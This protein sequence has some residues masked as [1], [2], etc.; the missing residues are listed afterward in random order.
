MPSYSPR[1]SKSSKMATN[2]YQKVYRNIGPNSPAEP[3]E[4]RGIDV[5]TKKLRLEKPGRSSAGASRTSSDYVMWDS[6]DSMLSDAL[7]DVNEL[8]PIASEVPAPLPND[9]LIEL[10]SPKRSKNQPTSEFTMLTRRHDKNKARSPS[11]PPEQV[12]VDGQPALETV[13][14]TPSAGD[15]PQS[16]RPK[17]KRAMEAVD[18]I[19]EVAEIVQRDEPRK[20]KQ[21]K[22]KLILSK[23]P[24]ED[25]PP[26]AHRPAL[27][28]GAR[29]TRLENFIIRQ[30]QYVDCDSLEKSHREDAMLRCKR[31]LM[32]LQLH[33]YAAKFNHCTPVIDLL[34][35]DDES[36][37]DS[38]SILSSDDIPKQTLDLA[39]IVSMME[40]DGLTSMDEFESLVRMV[41]STA[42]QEHAPETDMYR[43][44]DVLQRVFEY[45][46]AE[47][48]G[49]LIPY[50]EPLEPQS[51]PAMDCYLY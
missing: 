45:R 32:T 22:K 36:L 21:Q 9:A 35:L 33:P 26:P 34:P 20:E 41:F 44:A 15:S 40:S 43:M 2:P 7:D 11:S 25:E 3:E 23:K 12:P 51:L 31:M 39:S 27:V 10:P 29:A 6:G 47:L 24:K 46:M 42:K 28:D 16:D 5:P 48:R 1:E 17:R 4:G 49:T 37:S 13:P 30:P 8:S 50:P 38:S 14:L 19:R 18:R